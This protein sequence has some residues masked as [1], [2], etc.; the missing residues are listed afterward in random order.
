MATQRRLPPSTW[1]SPTPNTTL[2]KIES[3]HDSTFAFCSQPNVGHRQHG[4]AFNGHNVELPNSTVSTYNTYSTPNAL[5]WNRQLRNHP[6]PRVSHAT[7][8]R[9][10]IRINAIQ[11]PNLNQ[12]YA[13]PRNISQD[14]RGGTRR[15]GIDMRVARKRRR[16][17]RDDELIQRRIMEGFQVLWRQ[18][19]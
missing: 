16:E 17:D 13:I 4:I 18:R 8:R 15:A 3:L 12:A 5:A 7:A 19:R 10:L 1:I 6:T 14:N 11:V 9:W 2:F